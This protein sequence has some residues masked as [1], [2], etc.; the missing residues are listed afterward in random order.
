MRIRRFLSI[1]IVAASARRNCVRFWMASTAYFPLSHGGARVY[2]VGS[3][4]LKKHFNTLF[5]YTFFTGDA[6]TACVTIP[7]HQG[8]RHTSRVY[9]SGRGERNNYLSFSAG[10]GH[11]SKVHCSIWAIL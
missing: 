4:S 2:G 5:F 11:V 10:D 1:S 7:Q 8:G 9:F 3:R 6:I